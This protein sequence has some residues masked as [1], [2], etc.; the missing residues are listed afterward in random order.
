MTK[1]ASFAKHNM[2]E[3]NNN[4]R[5]PEQKQICR[6]IAREFPEYSVLMEE[7]VPYTKE[8]GERTC[9]IS[10]IMIVELGVYYRL[11]GDIHYSNDRQI[12]HDWEQKLYLEKLGYL[13]ID[14]DTRP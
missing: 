9:G 4:Q 2:R 13:V 6:E 1:S 12:E 5:R 11:N 7:M 8:N 14:V 10:D 3:A